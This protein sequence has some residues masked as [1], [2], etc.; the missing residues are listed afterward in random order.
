MFLKNYMEDVVNSVYEDYLKSNPEFCKCERCR[1]DMLALALSHLRGKYA[2]G[3]EGEIFAKMSRED[4]QVRA[5]A[6]LA[7]N[8]AAKT[9]SNYPKH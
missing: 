4:R 8:E 1:Q 7:I 2:V 9:V 6:L 5:D 3:L